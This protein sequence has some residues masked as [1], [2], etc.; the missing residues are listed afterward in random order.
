[1]PPGLR[2]SQLPLLL[3]AFSALLQWSVPHGWMIAG[4]RDGLAIL[5]PCPTVA[6]ALAAINK[7]SADDPH[8]H[9]DADHA[10]M[11][12]QASPSGDHSG[13]DEGASLASAM[14]DFAALAAPVLPPEPFILA[15]PAFFVLSLRAVSPP[16]TAPGRGLAAPPP[17]STGP[18]TIPA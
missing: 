17:P 16:A 13:H 2:H 15:E 3:A 9:H 8:A 6:P 14:C 10:A 12:H 1:M 7:A 5:V 18:P 11:G 4:P